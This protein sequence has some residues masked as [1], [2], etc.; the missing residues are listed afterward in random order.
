MLLRDQ[1]STLLWLRDLSICVGESTTRRNP[2][3]L[4][5]R[6]NSVSK[7]TYFSTIW[8]SQTTCAD[9]GVKEPTW[10][11]RLGTDLAAEILLRRIW[12]GRTNYWPKYTK[13]Q[14]RNNNISP[15]IFTSPPPPKKRHPGNPK[16][17]TFTISILSTPKL[18]HEHLHRFRPGTL[19]LGSAQGPNPQLQ[20]LPR[21]QTLQLNPGS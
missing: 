3:A 16:W 14:F 6:W 11:R 18:N 5:M 1:K 8:E 20:L 2:L 13:P 17:R 21:W 4:D 9:N 7:N 19:P 15:N 12:C 10:R